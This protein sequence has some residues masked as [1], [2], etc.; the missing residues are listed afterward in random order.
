MKVLVCVCACIL[1]Y[2]SFNGRCSVKR[3]RRWIIEILRCRRMEI[4]S[5]ACFACRRWSRFLVISRVGQ[6]RIYAPYM[7]VYMVISFQKYRIYTVYTYKRMVL[8]NPSHLPSQIKMTHTACLSFAMGVVNPFP[9][10]LACRRGS[11]CLV[12]SLL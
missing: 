2:V 8:D 11:R 1:E 4:T 12:I 6:N 9:P 10:L 5:K 7:T 3:T